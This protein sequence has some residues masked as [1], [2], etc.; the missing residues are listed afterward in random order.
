[1]NPTH[2]PDRVRVAG[3]G[4]PGAQANRRDEP[5]KVNPPTG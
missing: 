3:P 1:M 4:V 2:A 5:G